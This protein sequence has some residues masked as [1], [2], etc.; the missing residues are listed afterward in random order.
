MAE[1]ASATELRK[2]CRGE[3]LVPGD[4]GYDAARTVFNAMIDRRPAVIVRCAGVADVIA[5]V[6]YARDHDLPLSV[7]G[8]GHS[9]PGYAVCDGGV[10][11]DLSRSEERRVGK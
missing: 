5:A 1:T 6:T 7:R 8:G 9:V 3:V 10:M 11:L 4:D 2:A